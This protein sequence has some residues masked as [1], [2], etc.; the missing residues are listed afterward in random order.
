M[1]SRLLVVSLV[2]VDFLSLKLL[3]DHTRSCRIQSTRCMFS[4]RDFSFLQLRTIQ[5]DLI[6]LIDSIY[7]VDGCCCSRFNAK[8]HDEHDFLTQTEDPRD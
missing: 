5:L 8:Q 4:S 2:R 1:K 6:S 7:C 3:I